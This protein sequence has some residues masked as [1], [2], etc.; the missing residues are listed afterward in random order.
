VVVYPWK[1]CKNIKV[2][3]INEMIT[4]RLHVLM[5]GFVENY[6]I[7]TSHGEERLEGI[8]MHHFL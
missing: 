2:F 3:N 7:W 1:K 6:M 5:N 4:I 8:I